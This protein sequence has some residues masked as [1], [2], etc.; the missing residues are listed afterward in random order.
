M[1]IQMEVAGL[2]LDPSGNSPILILK[3]QEGDRTLPIWIGI[4]EAA[5][6]AM[7]LQNV[8]FPRPMTH[9]LFK[10]FIGLMGAAME[11]VDILDLKDSTYF[12][13]ITFNTKD[14]EQLVLDSRPSDAIAL[15]IRTKAPVFVAE[16]VLDKS[17]TEQSAGEAAD[18]SEEGKKW[19]EYLATLNPDDFSK[20]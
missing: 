18:Q 2:A 16:E 15:A 19:A 6:I 7:A 9:D 20:V 5:S 1:L 14:G 10:N 11:K 12:A 4:M 8:E 17:S 3:S 13:Q